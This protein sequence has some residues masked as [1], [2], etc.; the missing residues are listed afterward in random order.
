MIKAQRMPLKSGIKISPISKRN[1][2][3]LLKEVETFTGDAKRIIKHEAD[4]AVGRMKQDAPV[5]SGRLRREIEARRINKDD[6]IIESIA[7]DPATG[8]DYAP[9]QE[10]GLLGYKEQP[11]FRKNIRLF[12][13]RLT[14]RLQRALKNKI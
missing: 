5:D 14:Q 3:R 6:V 4:N 1:L 13:D 2:N 8:R 10:Y 12:I 7:I 11:Y 9:I